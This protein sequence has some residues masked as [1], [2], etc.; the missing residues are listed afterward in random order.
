MQ[1]TNNTP[2]PSLCFES[3]GPEGCPVHTVV[4]RATATIVP[5]APLTLSDEQ[6]PLK[7]TDCFGKPGASSLKYPSDL[8]PFKPKTDIVVIAT[9]YPPAKHSR[10]WK[11]GV[12]VGQHKKSLL[13]LG[14]VPLAK[15]LFARVAHVAGHPGAQGRHPV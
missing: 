9:A 15:E 14:G 1:F 11:I 4:V 8:A 10:G 6:L 3:T 2:F 12:T 7:L 13:V 5:G